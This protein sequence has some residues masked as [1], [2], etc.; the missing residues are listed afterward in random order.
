MGIVVLSLSH[1]NPFAHAFRAVLDTG[2]GEVHGGWRL[3]D[4]AAAWVLRALQAALSLAL[5]M[6][7]AT[8]IEGHRARRNVQITRPYT[9]GAM[10]HARCAVKCPVACFCYESDHLGLQMLWPEPHIVSAS[11][12]RPDSVS[13]SL[14]LAA[15]LFTSIAAFT[16]ASSAAIRTVRWS[17]SARRCCAAAIAARSVAARSH[18][19]TVRGVGGGSRLLACD[20]REEADLS[21]S[22]TGMTGPPA[23]ALAAAAPAGPSVAGPGVPSNAIRTGRCSVLEYAR[24]ARSSDAARTCS[25]FPGRR[26]TLQLKPSLEGAPPLPPMFEHRPSWGVAWRGVE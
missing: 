15:A 5:G 25:Q 2:T 9:D 6:A 19:A 3:P 12:A 16:S 26:Q 14:A 8:G 13:R 11:A 7:R 24:R 23:A 22:S 4:A 17:D 20:D 10:G 18:A 1:P 21:M